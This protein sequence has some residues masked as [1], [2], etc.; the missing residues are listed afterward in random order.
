M[1]L[2]LRFLRPA[3]WRGAALVLALPV[4]TLAAPPALAAD[5]QLDPAS[6]ARVVASPSQPKVSRTTPFGTASRA[7]VLGQ[8]TQLWIEGTGGGVTLERKSGARWVTAAS[9]G[10]TLQN[11]R[12]YATVRVPAAM[13]DSLA[14]RTVEFRI[15]AAATPTTS[16]WTS[17]AQRLTLPKRTTKVVSS[18]LANF[19]GSI[20]SAVKTNR[21]S[22]SFNN[23]EGRTA[24]LQRKINGTWRTVASAKV[25]GAIATVK[26]PVPA[27]ARAVSSYRW[28]VSATSAASA[29]NSGAAKIVT[30]NPRK[31]TGYKG[32]LH[33][34]I[35]AYCPNTVIQIHS[36]AGG[37]AGLAYI[38]TDQ[39]AIV[40]GL[41]GN[42]RKLAALHE[43]A[44]L[45]QYAVA[46]K[47]GAS[48]EQLKVR[49][50]AIYGTSGNLG[51]EMHAT[52]TAK[53]MGASL[54]KGAGYT[55]NC[56]GARGRA[57]AAIKAG[58]MP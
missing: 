1:T 37:Y 54:I 17:G 22:A 20:V 14:G 24:A 28:A 58:R 32:V 57:G 26:M 4:S 47:R 41:S 39:I 56:S 33:R 8:G 5:A 40:S 34:Q 43:C 25:R 51:M 48:W 6:K 21:V 9:L 49:L 38:G 50:N 46:T 18:T 30:E 2:R 19:S 23:A 13:V 29:A 31:Y 10:S 15:K 7:T 3:V 16:A 45:R 12:R 44:H 42:F 11:G 52:C 36:R 35:K 27:S 53:A 55:T